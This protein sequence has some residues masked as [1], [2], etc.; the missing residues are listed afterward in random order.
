[1]IN[2]EREEGTGVGE[3]GQFCLGGTKMLQGQVSRVKQR[4]LAGGSLGF[5]QENTNRTGPVSS[6]K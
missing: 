1:M 5:R 2:P 3:A 4:Q 6:E